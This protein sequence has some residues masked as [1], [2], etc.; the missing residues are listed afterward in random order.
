MTQL[1]FLIDSQMGPKKIF[2]HL[3]RKSEFEEAST[4]YK[5]MNYSRHY[6]CSN[7]VIPALYLL[8]SV[9]LFYF[10]FA[11]NWNPSHV[12]CKHFNK[13]SETHQC[14]KTLLNDNYKV[15]SYQ[16]GSASSILENS[17]SHSRKQPFED[18]C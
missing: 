10:K 6:I 13:F 12:F 2:P 9:T 17:N 5:Q 16:S 11:T 3:K 7:T 15:F 14:S 4:Y 18:V 8:F 1:Y